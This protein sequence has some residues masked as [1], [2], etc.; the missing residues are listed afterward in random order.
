MPA[1]DTTEDATDYAEPRGPQV[2]NR[3]N[4]NNKFAF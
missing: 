1:R 4:D 2:T 3:R